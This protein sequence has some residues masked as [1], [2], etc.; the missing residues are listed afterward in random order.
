V[1]CRFFN[2]DQDSPEAV[3]RLNDFPAETQ[4][5]LARHYAVAFP[6]E[7]LILAEDAGTIVGCLHLFDA[8]FPWAIL[9]GFYLKP[10]YRTLANA[11]ALGR[12]GEDELRK[13]GVPFY[14]V[15]ATGRLA[16]GLQRMNLRPLSPES[17]TMLGRPLGD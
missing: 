3:A 1:V 5:W 10:E 15:H 8:G 2:P 16:A 9:D 7:N 13:R 11:L 12:A 4:A 14:I 6:P 17:F